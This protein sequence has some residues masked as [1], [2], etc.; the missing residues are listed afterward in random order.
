MNIAIKN[1]RKQFIG[2]FISFES[3]FD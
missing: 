3:C 2:C 1:F